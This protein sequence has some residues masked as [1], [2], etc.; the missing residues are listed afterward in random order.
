MCHRTSLLVNLSS[1]QTVLTSSLFGGLN[2]PF[3]KMYPELKAL[4]PGIL[5]NVSK[6]QIERLQV[7][8]WSCCFE[9]YSDTLLSHLYFF[10]VIQTLDFLL[11]TNTIH[12]T[13]LDKHNFNNTDT[14]RGRP[15]AS[16]PLAQHSECGR[17]T[18]MPLSSWPPK[19]QIERCDG[20]KIMLMPSFKY[21]LDLEEK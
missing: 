21:S 17:K 19:H 3:V 9:I 12:K 20:K 11:F 6:M 13:L 7:Y 18:D 5:D 8:K 10:T 14:T 4:S 15:K 2:C 16:L 1:N